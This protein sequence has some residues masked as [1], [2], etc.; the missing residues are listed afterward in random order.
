VTVP[1]RLALAVIG[2]S[3]TVLG[4]DSAFE[5]HDGL[6]LVWLV[7][8]L[9]G[10]EVVFVSFRGTGRPLRRVARLLHLPPMA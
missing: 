4:V 1:E 8:G 10:L 3:I 2:L 6:Q 7:V 5:A 9:V